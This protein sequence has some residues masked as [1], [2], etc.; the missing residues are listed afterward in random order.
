[1]NEQVRLRRTDKVVA[2]LCDMYND[3]PERAKK[4][5]GVGKIVDYD[6]T[7]W[8]I[9]VDFNGEELWVRRYDL[10]YLNEDLEKNYD[11]ERI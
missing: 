11:A 1:M 2:W 5:A 4:L 7:T 8:S 3:N 10:I 9:I 6:Y